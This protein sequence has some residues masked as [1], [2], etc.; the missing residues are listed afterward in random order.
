MRYI[1]QASEQI[2]PYLKE[3][4][5]IIV[6]STVYPGATEEYFVPI[7]KKL[8]L[9]LGKN[10]FLGFSPEREDPGNK[11]YSISKGNIPK[12]VSGSTNN[13]KKRLLSGR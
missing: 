1:Y 2:K 11:K 5:A 3:D 10:F 9:S 4:Q 8:K 6:E 7:I 13:C 12:I